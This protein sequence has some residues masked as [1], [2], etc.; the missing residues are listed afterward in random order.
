MPFRGSSKFINL[1]FSYIDLSR[2]YM[3]SSQSM[4]S[5][6]IIASLHVVNS[7]LS[8]NNDLFSNLTIWFYIWSTRFNINLDLRVLNLWDVVA[9]IIMAASGNFTG[10]AQ[11][12]S[13]IAQVQQPN[14][15]SI[16]LPLNFS[17]KNSFLRNLTFS[18]TNTFVLSVMEEY[19]TITLG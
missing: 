11:L 17:T 1:V 19:P 7:L 18:V 2:I 12:W 9:M 16:V 5:R 8:H 3:A 6:L 10:A 13:Y 15:S 4:E 14:Q